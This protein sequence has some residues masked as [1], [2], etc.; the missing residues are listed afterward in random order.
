M[1][2]KYFFLTLFLALSVLSCQL[3]IT[4]DT[5]DKS[6]KSTPTASLNESDP[7]NTITEKS[8]PI[9]QDLTANPHDENQEEIFHSDNE[10]LDEKSF[11]EIMAMNW[12][13]LTM[14]DIQVG[15]LTYLDDNSIP[16][17]ERFQQAL[18]HIELAMAQGD[19]EK[20]DALVDLMLHLSPIEIS[21][22]AMDLY[23]TSG[24]IAAKGTLLKLITSGSEYIFSSEAT[25]E[26]ANAH[27]PQAM[28]IN[29]F[30]GEQLQLE[31][32]TE[33]A[34]K[35]FDSYSVLANSAEMSELI[36]D[37]YQKGSFSKIDSNR[38][39]DASLS[40]SLES[41]KQ[42]REMLPLALEMLEN[43]SPTDS[44]Y[45]LDSLL[46]SDSQKQ[47]IPES[48]A[49]IAAYL[50]RNEPILESGSDISADDILNKADWTRLKSK[51]DS[52]TE[53][54]ML[55]QQVN[56]IINDKSILNS[57]TIITL[58]SEEVIKLVRQHNDFQYLLQRLDNALQEPN[59][60]DVEQQVYQTALIE[61][62]GG[63]S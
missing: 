21:D 58:A 18:N 38:L 7:T 45:K 2:K 55:S 34:N 25:Q 10:D 5:V 32:D 52:K 51:V 49:K 54:E 9:I 40:I 56:K 29:Q 41:E 4:E 61:L 31:Q 60:S 48:R 50:D 20:A 23:L 62:K 15:L 47:L 39:T 46:D 44:L 27:L 6:Q 63:F 11:N 16:R 19:L 33:L 3:L 42:Q 43:Q 30:I 17:E 37:E 24:S 59:I 12:D 8:Q 26:D 57:A 22:Q 1:N 53:V 13:T 28:K 14:A 35:L 36:H